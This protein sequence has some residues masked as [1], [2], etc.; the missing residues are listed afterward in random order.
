MKTFFW[1]HTKKGHGYLCGR[2]FCRQKLHKNLFGHVLENSGKDPSPPQKICL[3]LRQWSKGISDH[4]APLL[5]GQRGKYPRHASI[6]RRPCAYYSTRTL[7]TRCCR[8]QCVTAVNINHH[9]YPKTEQLITA[10]ISS[11]ALKQRGSR[12][13]WALR[14][15]SSQLQKYKAARMSRRIAVDQKVCYWDGEHPG[16]T[17]WNL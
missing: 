13:H 3:L 9:R 10:K 2:E 5:K 8:L 14:Q 6:L 16:L 11:N 15:R 4:I 1:G 7:F 12:T 17:V